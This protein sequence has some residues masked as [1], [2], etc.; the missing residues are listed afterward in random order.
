MKYLCRDLTVLREIFR[1]TR[2]TQ[3]Q[4]QQQQQQRFIHLICCKHFHFL[5]ENNMTR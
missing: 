4:Q 2:G 1:S 5:K 3:Q